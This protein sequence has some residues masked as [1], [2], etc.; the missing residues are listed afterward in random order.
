[1]SSTD[2]IFRATRMDMDQVS[3]EEAGATPGPDREDSLNAAVH[4][5]IVGRFHQVL[6]SLEVKEKQVLYF[7]IGRMPERK[8]YSTPEVSE[9]VGVSHEE[10]E[11][12]YLSVISRFRGIFCSVEEGKVREAVRSH[13]GEILI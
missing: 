5:D 8:A 2:A 12:I 11:S 9:I 1:M 6:A 3:Q 13:Q 7:L 4:E 10:V